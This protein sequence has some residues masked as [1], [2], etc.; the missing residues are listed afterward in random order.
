[1]DVHPDEPHRTLPSRRSR[2][3]AGGRSDKDGYV[4]AA[5]PGRSQGR[6]RTTPGSQP[7]GY[8]RPAL[9][10]LPRT[11]PSRDT[12][13]AR[14]P[15]GS[16]AAVSSPDNGSAFTARA[17]LTRLRELGIAHR[18]GGYRDPESQAFIESWFSKLK[19]REIWPN[20]YETL[21]DAIRGVT[22]YIDRYHQRPHSRL[23][24]QTPLEVAAVWRNAPGP[25]K[26]PA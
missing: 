12:D 17:T 11:A 6:P 3:E 2:R 5:H 14:D 8:R 21:D 24:Y 15:D 4:L 7:I 20:E 23:G 13:P 9:P 18:R 16:I 1:M 10:A 19:E 22:R 26:S 25:Q